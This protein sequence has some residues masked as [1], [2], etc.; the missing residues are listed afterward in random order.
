MKQKQV[1]IKSLPQ[2]TFK[3]IKPIPDDDGESSLSAT[4]KFSAYF[5]YD[6]SKAEFLYEHRGLVKVQLFE[7]QRTF[8]FIMRK[9]KIK[10]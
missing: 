2:T 4:G 10:K 3:L 1:N 8:H 6:G 7:I 9:S 5:L